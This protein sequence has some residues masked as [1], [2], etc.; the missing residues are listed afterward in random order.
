[1]RE[2]PK[3]HKRAHGGHPLHGGHAAPEKDESEVRWLI[4]Y[5]DFMMQ[6]VCLFILLYSVSATDAGKTTAIAQSWREEQGLQPIAV[7][8]DPARGDSIPLTVSM[9]PS[10]LKE[11]QTIVSRYPEGGQIRITPAADGFRLQIVHE[12]FEEGSSALTKSGERYLDLAAQV[13]HPYQYGVRSMEIVGHT[14]TGDSE[15]EDGSALRLALA[16]SRAAVR[17]VTRT[18]L[19]SRLDALRLGAA[20][21]GPHEPAVDNADPRT[22]AMNRRIDFVVHLHDDSPAVAGP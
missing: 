1:M 21:R 4:S 5:S 10:T 22:R 18:G 3:E 2:N 15:R 12:L 7:P 20:G 17:W 13:L 19:P 14:A 16:R 8:S 6:L 11:I 9:L